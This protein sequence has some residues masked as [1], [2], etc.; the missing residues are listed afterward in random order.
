MIVTTL[1]QV[2]VYPGLLWAGALALLLIAALGRSARGQNAIRRGLSALRGDGS[3]PHALSAVFALIAL[4]LLPWPASP[5][6]ATPNQDLWR[7]WAFIEGSFLVALLPGLLSSLP[8]MHRSAT[9]EAQIGV[10]GRAALWFA[11]LVGYAWTG[12]DLVDLA[13][14]LLGAVAAL[15]ALPAAAGWQPFGD[16]SGL[17]SGGADAHLPSAD[18]GLARWARDLRSVLLIALIASVFVSAP[19]LPWWQQL[20]LKVW[21][22]LA[23]ALVGRG[24]RGGT[25]HRTLGGALRYC[26]LLVL[27]LAAIALAGRT[28]LVG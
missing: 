14:L 17:G 8:T 27:P 21:L 22:A 19:Q 9:R 1:F 18:V 23:V 26:W 6:A 5:W 15:F 7:L 28:W 10:S 20:A 2:L 11:V 16:E 24:M 3:L 4:A 13:P 25:V 12:D